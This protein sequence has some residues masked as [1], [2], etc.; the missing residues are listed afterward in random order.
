MPS[1]F[2]KFVFVSLV[3]V[4]L[5]ACSSEKAASPGTT[6]TDGRSAGGGGRGG[7]G[8][9]GAVPVVTAKA[10]AKSVPLTLPAVGAGEALS[11]V[12]IRAQI[13]GQLSQ[14]HFAEGQE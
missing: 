5:A 12:Q 13:T 2:H 6:A 8:G 1:P 11:T 4:C 3:G 14:I 10:Q 7:R 9:G